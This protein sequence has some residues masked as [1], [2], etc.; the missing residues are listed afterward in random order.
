MFGPKYFGFP[1]PLF[2]TAM[3]MF[4]QF[5]LAAILRKFWAKQF[6]PENQPTTEVYR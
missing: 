2:V 5:A 6:K 1:N 3:H 4:V